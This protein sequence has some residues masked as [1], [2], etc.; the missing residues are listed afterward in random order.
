[1][2]K[3]INKK[4]LAICVAAAAFFVLPLSASAADKLV[5]KDSNF[6]EV[7]KVDD[8]GTISG[9]QL[10]MGTTTPRAPFHLNSP[11]ALGVL[12]NVGSVFYPSTTT[13]LF[14]TQDNSMNF[15]IAVADNTGTAGYRGTFKGLRARGTLE[16]PTAPAVND[17]VLTLMGSIWDGSKLQNTAEVGFVVDGP[18][19]L[20]SG[21]QRIV[22]STSPKSV[23]GKVERLT[24]KSDGKVGINEPNPTSILQV[25]GLPVYENNT[26]AKAGGLTAGAFYRTATGVLMVAY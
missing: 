26:Q 20:G 11:S 13:G 21:P 12:P 6:T 25:S 1:M 5:V 22:F 23:A 19:S 10:G 14:S 18:V 2:K 15:S 16:N 3:M 24:I 9:A 8:A 7:F 17:L 4:A